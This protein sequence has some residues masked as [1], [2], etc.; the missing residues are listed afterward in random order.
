MFYVICDLTPRNVSYSMVHFRQ[1]I[2]SFITSTYIVMVLN[3]G[4]KNIKMLFKM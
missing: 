3:H 1:H 2:Y 4:T